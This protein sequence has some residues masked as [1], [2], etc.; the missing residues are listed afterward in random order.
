MQVMEVRGRII[1]EKQDSDVG[2]CLSPWQHT[3]ITMSP[4]Q[5]TIITM[6]PHVWQH[7]IITMSPWQ[8]THVTMAAHHHDHVT[9]MQAYKKKKTILD[10]SYGAPPKPV[11]GNDSSELVG[12][13]AGGVY[14]FCNG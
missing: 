9:H 8:H 10:S 14:V 3:I 6:S 11:A 12:Q 5:H 2:S 13:G 7:T 1:G 4:W